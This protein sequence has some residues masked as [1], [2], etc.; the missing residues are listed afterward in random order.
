MAIT[1]VNLY[2]LAAPIFMS[3]ISF[4]STISVKAFTATQSSN[5]NQLPSLVLSLSTTR[6]LMLGP[7]RQQSSCG[8]QQQQSETVAYRRQSRLQLQ[9]RLMQWSS[10]GSQVQSAEDH[11]WQCS[12]RTAAVCWCTA[13]CRRF[14]RRVGQRGEPRRSQL[15]AGRQARG[16]C[17]ERRLGSACAAWTPWNRSSSAWFRNRPAWTVRRRTATSRISPSSVAV[18]SLSASCRRGLKPCPEHHL[19]S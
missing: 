5:Y 19:N 7:R 13:D 16:R 3:R 17:R 8:W 2:L 1:Q 12:H 11:Q 6:L 4:H 9:R 14:H 18:T 15:A 10:P